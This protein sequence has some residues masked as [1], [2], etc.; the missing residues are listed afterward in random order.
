[1]GQRANQGLKLTGAAHTWFYKLK[2]HYGRLR[3]LSLPLN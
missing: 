2:C 3:Q 1:M